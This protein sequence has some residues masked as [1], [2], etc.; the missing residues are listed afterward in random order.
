MSRDIFSVAVDAVHSLYYRF[1]RCII[2]NESLCHRCYRCAT[3]IY[4]LC[5]RCALLT[6]SLRAFP[7]SNFYFNH[8]YFDATASSSTAQRPHR[9]HTDLTTTTTTLQRL[10]CGPLPIQWPTFSTAIF[11]NMFKKIATDAR[12]QRTAPDAY[13]PQRGH[14]RPHRSTNRPR[15]DC[16]DS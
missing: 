13:R 11:L 2:A 5:I 12:P 14:S 8:E 3:A 1:A 16:S 6:P 15:K 7:R 9:C 10:H 4:P